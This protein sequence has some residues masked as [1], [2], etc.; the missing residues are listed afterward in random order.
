MGIET[1]RFHWKQ[2]GL[3]LTTWIR[4]IEKFILPLPCFHVPMFPCSML[5]YKD[6][7]LDPNNFPKDKMNE[8]VDGLHNNGQRYGNEELH[9]NMCIITLCPDSILQQW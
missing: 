3:T 6:F 4:Y 5:Q 2:C 1:C 9:Y 8:F 7:T